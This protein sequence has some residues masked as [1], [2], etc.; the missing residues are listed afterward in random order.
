MINEHLIDPSPATRSSKGSRSKR[1]NRRMSISSA[2]DGIRS[3]FIS[4]QSVDRIPNE[5]IS[6]EGYKRGQLRNLDGSLMNVED[7]QLAV[8]KLKYEGHL[9]IKNFG[10]KD[11]AWEKQKKL[12][13]D[14]KVA[15]K[16]KD[17]M[18][19][20][21]NSKRLIPKHAREEREKFRQRMR[22]LGLETEAFRK[23][24]DNLKNKSKTELYSRLEQN[25]NRAGSLMMD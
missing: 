21:E 9:P 23:R 11:S 3:D 18:T 14:A 19:A 25:M 1:S 5:V 8:R 10:F 6:E 22:D 17:Y 13:E 15:V 20:I 12:N 24:Y 7:Y 4:H 2:K 16:K